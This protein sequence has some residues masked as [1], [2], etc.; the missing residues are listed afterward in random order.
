M[1][2][3]STITNED[4]LGIIEEHG[5][6]FLVLDPYADGELL[7]LFQSQPDWT[8][9]FEDE[10]TVILARTDIACTRKDAQVAA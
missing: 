6:Q 1:T 9:D 8:V 10:E 7:R 4:W 3:S 5:V 2:A